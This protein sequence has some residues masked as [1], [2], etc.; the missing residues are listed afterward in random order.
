MPPSYMEVI[1]GS[2][3]YSNDRNYLKGRIISRQLYK[4]LLDTLLFSLP[5]GESLQAILRYSRAM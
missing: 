1:R 4:Y 2:D 3:D 5:L